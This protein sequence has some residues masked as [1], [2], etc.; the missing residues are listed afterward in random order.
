M[1]SL[2]PEQLNQKYPLACEERWGTRLG[3][4]YWDENRVDKGVPLYELLDDA[5]PPCCSADG[6][7]FFSFCLNRPVNSDRVQHCEF[8]G[9]CF[10][11]RPGCM[12]GCSYCGCGWN[13][14][15]DKAVKF[16]PDARGCSVP[17][18]ADL[19]T[20]GLA[21]EGYWGF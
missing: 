19:S 9:K 2:T 11:F 12:N 6:S 16:P 7:Q 14:R 8:C 3:D 4:H 20:R 15:Y 10:Y 17:A 1:N 21:M 5:E 13:F 18:D